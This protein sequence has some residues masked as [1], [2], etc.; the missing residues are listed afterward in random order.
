MG[1]RSAEI[2]VLNEGSSVVKLR[3]RISFVIDGVGTSV[4]DPFHEDT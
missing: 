1:G 2:P 3:T 4:R